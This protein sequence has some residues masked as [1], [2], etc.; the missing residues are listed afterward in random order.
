MKGTVVFRTFDPSKSDEKRSD[1]LKWVN[2]MRHRRDRGTQVM[3][4]PVTI[5]QMFA[6]YLEDAEINGLSKGTIKAAQSRFYKHIL[7]GYGVE[8]DMTT[9]TKEE[10]KLFLKNLAQKKDEQGKLL[11]PASRNRIRSLVSRMYAI[12]I[13]EDH[14]FSAF[15]VNPFDK[16][17]AAKEQQKEIKYFSFSELDQFLT[18]NKNN[19]YFSLF[20]F[21]LRT[22]TRIGEAV[23]VHGEQIDPSTHMIRIDR[24]FSSAENRV[25]P[26]T[27]N[28][29]IRNIYL[30]DEVMEALAPK[31]SAGPLFTTEQGQWVTPNY[32]LKFVLPQACERAGI[33]RITPHATRHTFAAHYL[34]NG[35][36]LWDLSKILGHSDT[37]VTE[38][39]Y[40]HFDNEHEIRRMKVVGKTQNVIRMATY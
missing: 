27:K 28:H 5:E 34:M 15:K 12:A 16:I 25:V 37:K 2:A 7:P 21:L 6:K 22:G 4:D 13:K 10:H 3:M 39:R 17:G 32:F 23:A 36:T 20:L 33:K 11:K 26:G 31:L 38:K 29:Q 35:G 1:A 19:H 8:L 30:L 9:V 14:F 24:Q 18:K 40:G